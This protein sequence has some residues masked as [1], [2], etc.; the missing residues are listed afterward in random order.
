M[1]ETTTIPGT[2]R[3]GRPALCRCAKPDWTQSI[4]GKLRC[5]TCQ[6]VP[7]V[8]RATDPE[9][10]TAL[11]KLTAYATIVAVR[12][13]VVAEPE[14]R[15]DTELEVMETPVTV[16]TVSDWQPDADDFINLKGKAYL[17]ARKRIQWM[18]GGNPKAHPEWGIVTEIVQFERGERQG[19]GRVKG[20]YA[21]VR[22]TVIDHGFALSTE[23]PKVIATGMK[24][25]WSENFADF[26]EKAET[27]AIA[28]ALAVAGYG[29]ETALDLD[30]GAEQD[31]PA[32]APVSAPIHNP[33]ARD[34]V[35]IPTPQHY[36]KQ[37]EAEPSPPIITTSTAP[38]AGK[39]GRQVLGSETQVREIS[40]LAKE[41]HLSP[42]GVT[43]LINTTLSVNL[44][45][46]EDRIAA[47]DTLVEYLDGLSA[48]DLGRVVVE[49]T[50]AVEARKTGILS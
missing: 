16:P 10:L 45:L 39:G 8:A 49:L 41:I 34:G 23:H 32:D 36:A 17:G 50:A 1:V 44:E 6:G 19:V 47:S 21:C 18:R 4:D 26:L 35:V 5:G 28:R 2:P 24:T 42:L 22:A 33:A 15:E 29:T 38:S 27:G 14:P 48:E 12:E 11:G 9:V 13:E 7:G 37:M 43:R 31:R 30:D 40:R 25:E 3:R 46:P 20:G